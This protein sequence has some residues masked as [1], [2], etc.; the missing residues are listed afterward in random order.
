MASATADCAD[1]GFPQALD[2]RS[3]SNK[4]VL[5]PNAQYTA[6]DATAWRC[7][8]AEVARGTDIGCRDYERRYGAVLTGVNHPKFV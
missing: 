3:S 4:E 5:S 2:A 6:R 7:S 1:G 8:G